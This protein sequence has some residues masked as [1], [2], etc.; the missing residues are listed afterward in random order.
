[1][2][3]ED[4]FERR[5]AFATGLHR[6]LDEQGKEVAPPPPLPDKDHLAMYRAMLQVRLL[7]TRMMLLQRQGRIGFYGTSTGEEGAVIGSASVL[8]ASDWIFPALRQG[9]ALLMRGF[10]LA[11]YMHHLFGTAGSVEMGRSMPCHYSDRE[12]NVVSWSSSMATQL[13]HAVGMAYAAKYRSSPDI[14]IGYLGDGATSE[15]DF[16]VAM[17]FAGVWKVPVVFVCQNNQWAI[18]VPIAKQTASE[19]LA[20]KALA[21][22]MPGVRVDGNDVLAVRQVTELAA[23]RARE[24]RGPSMIECVTY[25]MQ[26]HSTSDDPTRYRAQE[27]VEAWA[28]RDPIARY[29]A[30]L[31]QKGLWS[32]KAQA[33]IEAELNEAISAAIKEAESTAPPGLETLIEQVYEE[34]TPQLR[35]QFGGVSRL[36]GSH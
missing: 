32:E 33:E 13:P 21:Y 25:R 24:G 30:W 8:K 28:K 27:E 4:D 12:H 31:E 15:G 34:P 1:M 14:A 7:D 9:G 23:R 20:V 17:N 36:Q 35:E 16:H 10:P 29:R 11:K 6:V 26:G 2:S 3:A 22:G 5:K 19:S 18:S